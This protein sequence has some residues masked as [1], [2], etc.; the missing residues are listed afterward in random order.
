MLIFLFKKDIKRSPSWQTNEIKIVNIKKFNSKKTIRFWLKK[1]DC[2]K[3]IIGKEAQL[4][5][6]DPIAPE[7]V[8]FG[9]ILVNFLPLNIF[10]KIYPPTSEKKVEIK[11]QIRI[12]KE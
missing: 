5:T 1:L 10:P 9:L 6:T 2:I 4:K 12:I 7:Y 3:V 8:L 11:I